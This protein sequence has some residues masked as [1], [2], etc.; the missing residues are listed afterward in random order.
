VSEKA[1]SDR[2]S[3]AVPLPRRGNGLSRADRAR[4]AILEA[5]FAVLK[6]RGY[7]GASIDAIASVAGVSK[8]TI[9]ANWNS[10]AAMVVEL[11]GRFADD[12]A[13][14]PDTGDLREDLLL[15]MRRVV[16]V[17]SQL[18]GV[19]ESIIAEAVHNPMIAGFVNAWRR[20]ERELVRRSIDRGLIPADIDEEVATDLVAAMVYF[21]VFL[22]GTGDLPERLVDPVL[23]AWGAQT[24]P[25]SKRR[26]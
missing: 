20:H 6:E 4:E 5:T 7:A 13:L 1:S 3:A 17:G 12:A 26:P 24:G 14:T 11:L 23:R 22:A 8:T 18:R 21:R 10:K 19:S 25:R 9:Y 15:T 16:E 2:S